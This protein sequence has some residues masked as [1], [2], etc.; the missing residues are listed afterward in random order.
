MLSYLQALR[1]TQE[2]ST[3]VKVKALGQE[4]DRASV[5]SG[6]IALACFAAMIALSFLITR[7]I[8]KPLGNL[9]KKTSQIAAGNFN[10]GEKVKS[11][12]EIAELDGALDSMCNQLRELDQMKADFYASM[13]HE[14][15]TPLTSIK[16]GTQL[17]LDGVGG[18]TT[19]KQRKLLTI[20]AE[21][22]RRLISV[23]NSLLDLAKMEAGMMTFEFETGNIEPLIK[24]TVA[25]LAPLMEAKKIVL[26]SDL[27]AGLPPV[28]M[29]PERILLVLRNLL[30]NAVK[31]TP[32]GGQVE[33]AV[34]SVR[35]NLQVSVKDSGPGVA[36]EHLATIFDKYQQSRQKGA[37]SPQGT[38]LGLA[39][40][41]NIITSHGGQ[42]WAESQLG[43][44]SRFV[45]V[46]HS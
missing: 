13:S 4:A 44:G 18:A 20:L 11:P 1:F 37:L 15:R 8:T 40:V 6:W 36:A 32:N 5:I 7:S 22:S 35:G 41:K 27:P 23:V 30:G 25:E 14:L 38:G 3:F 46:L 17:L 28:R 24:R 43:H 39:I 45:F 26:R 34:A 2:R 9:K 21:E 10:A 12:P 33:I 19:E 29:D 31:F 42:V 16:E